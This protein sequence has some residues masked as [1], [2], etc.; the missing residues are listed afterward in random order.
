MVDSPN[1]KP[2]CTRKSIP[3]KQFS[4]TSDHI[5]GAGTLKVHVQDSKS[6]WYQ[7]M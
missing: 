1:N 2:Y 6:D 5:L 7:K 4:L 3:V